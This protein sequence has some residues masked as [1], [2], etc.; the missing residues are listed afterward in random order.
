MRLNLLQEI[1]LIL[2][3]IHVIGRQPVKNSSKTSDLTKRDV[4]QLNLSE[5]NGKLG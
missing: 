3:T 5:I 4:F 2:T 1:L